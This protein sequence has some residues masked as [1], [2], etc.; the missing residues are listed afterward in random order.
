[1][2]DFAS[3][4]AAFFSIHRAYL[5]GVEAGLPSAPIGAQLNAAARIYADSIE[6]LDVDS[7]QKIELLT[8]MH[9]AFAEMP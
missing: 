1:M 3:A 5:L 6:S 8:E 2:T 4:R 7:L 9:D